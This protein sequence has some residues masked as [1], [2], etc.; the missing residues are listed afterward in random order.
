MWHL[1]TGEIAV[2]FFIQQVSGGSARTDPLDGFV[3]AMAVGVMRC[4]LR[5]GAADLKKPDLTANRTHARAHACAPEHTPQW[6]SGE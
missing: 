4:E 2:H 5:L 3:N 1:G 6:L